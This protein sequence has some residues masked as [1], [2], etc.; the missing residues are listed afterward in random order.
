MH[1]SKGS[2]GLQGRVQVEAPVPLIR[3]GANLGQP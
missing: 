1:G 2:P 3:R